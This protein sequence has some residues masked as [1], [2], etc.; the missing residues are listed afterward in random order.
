MPD[1]IYPS[2]K[3]TKE[4]VLAGAVDVAREALLEI[5]KD[6]H[7][8]EHAGLVQDDER[9]LT[10]A[11][12][13]L[14]PG[15]KGWFWTVTLARAPRSRTVTIDEVSIRPGEE[16]LLAPK[17]I[18]WNDR[19]EPSDIGPSDR[20]PYKAADPNLQEHEGVAAESP[21]EPES[22]PE[23]D[24]EVSDAAAAPVASENPTEMPAPAASDD[25]E[26][27]PDLQGG[28]EETGVDA[29]AAS[30]WELG[31]G[32][33]RVLSDE[34]RAEAF[35]RWYRADNGP[36]NQGT[37]DAKAPCS[38]CGY[39][40]RMDGSARQLFGVCA[41]EWS[42]FDGKVVSLDHGCGA[43]SETDVPKA[44]PLWDQTNPVVDESDLEI[45]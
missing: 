38:T 15:Y 39:L 18:P 20:V 33:V 12:E 24:S 25:A 19:L 22:Q 42:P 13:C 6:E 7:I 29:D 35:R 27:N 34:G 8:G 43:H 23:A 5:T 9:V 14:M 17:W 41:N 2:L 11:F 21:A 40:M 10:H 37:R 44:S 45:I 31:L 3:A 30:Q 26:S 28:F 36:R 16:A 32:R 1:R 4:T